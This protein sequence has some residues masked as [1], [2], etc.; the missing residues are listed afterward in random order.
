MK[1]LQTLIITS[2]FQIGFS[3]IHSTDSLYTVTN[4]TLAYKVIKKD[5]LKLDLYKPKHFNDSKPLVIY[6]HGGGFASGSRDESHTIQFCT[7]LAEHGFP[8]ASISYRLTMKNKGFGC[9]IKAKEKLKAFDKASEDIS[10]ATKFLMKNSKDLKINTD[11]IVLAGTSSGAEAILNLVYLYDNNILPKNHK[12]A[13][14]ISLTGALTSLDNIN[15]STAIPTQLFHGTNDNLVPYYIA[16]HHFCEEADSGYLLLYG[17]RAIADRLKG[18][19][20]SYFLTS[21]IA[22]PHQR[23]S[24][25]MHNHFNDI[26]DFL[27]HDVIN[28]NIRQTERV[29]GF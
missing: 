4:T 3:Q 15:A 28:N 29:L 16:A 27:N 8:V 13:G 9:D 22:E 20:K 14:V 12:F 6:V 26:L 25:P 24:V 21:F 19:G 5:T 2:V 17:S 10:Y 18:L 1:I 23:S 11:N 7:K